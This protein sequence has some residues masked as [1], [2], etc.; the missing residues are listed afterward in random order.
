MVGEIEDEPPRPL[1]MFS[2]VGYSPTGESLSLGISFRSSR[3]PRKARRTRIIP[4]DGSWQPP[5]PLKDRSSDTGSSWLTNRFQAAWPAR[6]YT[7]SHSAQW[8]LRSSVALLLPHVERR[9]SV[10]CAIRQEPSIF[11]QTQGRAIPEIGAF[12]HSSWFR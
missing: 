11:L 2:S 9:R 3:A 5:E 12:R 1:T 8:R 7:T 6:G 4:G 10:L